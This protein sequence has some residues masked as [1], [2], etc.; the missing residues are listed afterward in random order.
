MPPVRVIPW[1]CFPFLKIAD[2]ERGSLML[3]EF[4][5]ELGDVSLICLKSRFVPTR[6]RSASDFLAKVLPQRI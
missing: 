2:A 6:L 3:D 1:S 4:M 5:S